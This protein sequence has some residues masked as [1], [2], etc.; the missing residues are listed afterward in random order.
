MY[1]PAE[2]VGLMGLR[3]AT[4]V[5][6]ALDRIPPGAMIDLMREIR[7]AAGDRHLHYQ[8]D[9]VTEVIRLLPCPLTLRPDQLGYT[10]YISETVLNCLKRLP[11]LYFTVPEVREILRVTPIE[12]EWLR[13]CWTPAHRE[14][15][16]IFGRLDAVVDYTT[17]MWKDSIK[18]ME[19]NLSGIGGLHIAPTS[20]RIIADLV[21]PAMLLQDPSIRLQ[22]A[23]DV[24]ELLLQ[25][26]M[27]HLEAIGRSEGQIVLVDPKYAAEGPDEPEALAA[28]YRTR[29][30]LSV[31]HADVS[32]LRLRGDEVLYGDTTVDLAY[33]DASVLDLKDL[34][35]EGVDVAPMRALLRQNRVVSS[36][37]AELDQKSCFEVFTDPALAERFLTVE[38][39]QVMRR[40]V[41]WT[42]I[43]SDR[44]TVSPTGERID[45]LEYARK[46]RESLVLKP[47]RA[48]GGE[49][50]LLGA[51]AAQGE[52]ESG[53]DRALVDDDRWVLQQ[54]AQI[55]VKSFQVLDESDRLHVEPFY[56]VMGMV[57]S[58]DGVALVGRASQQHVVNVAQH[59]GM[60]AVMVSAR[61]IHGAADSA[62]HGPAN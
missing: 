46:E 42:R 60:C 1:S 47:N 12:E 51:A 16:P 26:V 48:Y 61:A 56:V 36:I 54:V 39:R 50:V 44:R 22:L 10:H 27:E 2:E 52:W 15:N 8:H 3:L 55:P 7:C 24:R 17:A 49:G 35:E 40:H 13:D 5:Q 31:L 38:E 53:I 6:H 18:F 57:P 20:M 45:L 19:P 25:V 43:V 9:G 33:R 23:D 11:D 41:L 62:A 32:E 59:G 4:R 34:A 14:A 30:G 58:R 29:H 21:V 37:T 28:Y